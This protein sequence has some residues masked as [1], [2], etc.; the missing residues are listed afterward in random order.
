MELSIR[1][2][3]ALGPI[4]SSITW[5]LFKFNGFRVAEGDLIPPQNFPTLVNY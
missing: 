1:A 5:A 3:I 4:F 2:K